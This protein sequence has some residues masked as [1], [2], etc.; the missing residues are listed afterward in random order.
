MLQARPGLK[1]AA[2]AFATS[3]DHFEKKFG[4]IALRDP[5]SV[6]SPLLLGD[7]LGQFYPRLDLRDKPEIGGKMHIKIFP[8][9]QPP[10]AQEGWRWIVGRDGLRT[11][12]PAW[13]VTL[14]VFADRNGD[15]I[16]VDTASPQGAVYGSIQEHSFPISA[17]LASFLQALAFAMD[18]GKLDP[19]TGSPR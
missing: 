16:V 5:T 12:D 18:K 4:I 6:E 10:A 11:E 13:P 8:P 3:V 9:S 14:I 17:D 2:A 19:A 1:E 15:A 7:S